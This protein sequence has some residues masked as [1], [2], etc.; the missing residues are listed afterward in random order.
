[1]DCFVPSWSF[2]SSLVISALSFVALGL[3][4]AAVQ[5]ARSKLCL[6][7]ISHKADVLAEMVLV[8]A[9]VDMAAAALYTVRPIS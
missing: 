3:P 2:H 7:V 5:M 9:Y 1:M 4:A 8:I 6:S